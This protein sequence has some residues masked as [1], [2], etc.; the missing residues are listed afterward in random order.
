MFD[1]FF[2]DGVTSFAYHIEFGASERTL[3][4]KEVDEVM[5]KIVAGLEKELGLEIRK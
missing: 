3:E 1:I 2:K 4:N 5:G